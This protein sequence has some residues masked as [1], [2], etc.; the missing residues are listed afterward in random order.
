VGARLRNKELA[1]NWAEWARNFRS[2]RSTMWE[3][4]VAKLQSTVDTLELKLTLEQRKGAAKNFRKWAARWK[5][6]SGIDLLNNWKSGCR[7]AYKLKLHERILKQIMSRW[8][9]RGVSDVFRQWRENL[10][11]FLNS[12]MTGSA[13]G[14]VTRILK[15]WSHAL[16][17]AVLHKW[18]TNMRDE[19]LNEAQTQAIEVKAATQVGSLDIIIQIKAR[20]LLKSASQALNVWKEAFKDSTRAA[21]NKAQTA[22]IM[23]FVAK[24]IV[25][26]GVMYNLDMNMLNQLVNLFAVD[27]SMKSELAGIIT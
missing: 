18:R 10:R 27:K 22:A 23:R 2:D 19:R 26:L 6:S 16:N 24:R 3:N 12:K 4:R 21:K 7:A 17:Y 15:R 25:E 1:L 9:N 5:Y 11:T 14:I 8:R 20:W 13:S